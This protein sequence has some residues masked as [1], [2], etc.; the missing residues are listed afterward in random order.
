M[1]STGCG[2]TDRSEGAQAARAKCREAGTH[3]GRP[4]QG[5]QPGHCGVPT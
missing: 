5:A 4:S 3:P 1:V 2:Q